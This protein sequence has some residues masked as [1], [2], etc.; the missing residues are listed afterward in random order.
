[1]A[2]AFHAAVRENEGVVQIASM[3][4]LDAVEQS[5][6]F[7]LMLSIEGAEALGSS[8][9]LVDAFWALG[10]R[11]VGLTWSRR[12][13]FADGSGEPNA[14][15]LSRLGEGLGDRLLGARLAVD[16]P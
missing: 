13:A 4:D 7:G 3:G 2:A 5:D 16:P 9:E 14:G 1:M 10:V 8:P 6:Q 15:G 11:M 12:N